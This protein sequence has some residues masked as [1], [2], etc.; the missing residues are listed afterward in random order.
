MQVTADLVIGA[1][2]RVDDRVPALF[3]AKHCPPLLLRIQPW[4]RGPGKALFNTRNRAS[5][6]LHLDR[7]A[8]RRKSVRQYDLAIEILKIAKFECPVA[9]GLCLQQLRVRVTDFAAV[10]HPFDDQIDVTRHC[11]IVFQRL[12]Q[13]QPHVVDPLRAAGSAA[14]PA[15]AARHAVRRRDDAAIKGDLVRLLLNLGLQAQQ[16]RLDVLVGR[17]IDIAIGLKTRN[18]SFRRRSRR[19]GRDPLLISSRSWPASTIL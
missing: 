4:T 11:A 6:R 2:Q 16:A 10:L 13:H 14:D 9:I 8:F 3:L 19:S 1:D 18:V 12:H 15:P 7:D 5:L 17:A